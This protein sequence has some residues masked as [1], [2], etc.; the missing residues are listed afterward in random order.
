MTEVNRRELLCECLKINNINYRDVVAITGKSENT[1]F[2]WLNGSLAV[3]DIAILTIYNGLLIAHMF[4]PRTLNRVRNQI[5]QSSSRWGY[6]NKTSNGKAI[7]VGEK[8]RVTKRFVFSGELL[9]RREISEK[10]KI[11]LNTLLYRIKNEHP[12]TD[13]T[14]IVNKPV[15][16][17]KKL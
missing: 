14:E 3:P 12:G 5:L 9:T 7:M 17:S 1:V 4:I 8:I 6:K 10:A 15:Q 2:K 13:V 11:N 16:R